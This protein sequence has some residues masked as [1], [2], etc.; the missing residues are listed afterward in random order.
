MTT[1]A[2]L[3]P[4]WVAAARQIQAAQLADAER[5][6][7]GIK[8][9]LVVRE[10]PFDPGRIDA[11]LDTSSGE[12]VLDLG[13]LAE[14]EVVATLGYADAKQIL[15]DDNR[16]LAAQAYFSGRIQIQG[17]LGKLLELLSRPLLPMQQQMLDEVRSITA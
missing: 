4:E 16:D 12:W 7:D 5:P 2:F 8:V 3:S 10:V 15:V 6:L 14:A 1:H 9:N 11:H 13:H 17:D